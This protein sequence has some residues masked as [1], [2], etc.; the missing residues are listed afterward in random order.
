MWNRFIKKDDQQKTKS[1]TVDS[2]KSRLDQLSN[3]T[4]VLD[5]DN[6]NR[7]EGGLSSNNAFSNKYDWN[8]SLGGNTPL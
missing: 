6:M 7:I 3:N 8:S 2:E 5:T 4:T 1:T